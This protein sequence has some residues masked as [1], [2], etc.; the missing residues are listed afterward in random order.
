MRSAAPTPCWWSPG[1]WSCWPPRPAWW[2]A[3]ATSPERRPSRP[4]FRWVAA[5][6]GHPPAA[7]RGRSA[8]TAEAGEQ[9]GERVGV[10]VDGD[11]GGEHSGLAL[12]VADGLRGEGVDGVAHGAVGG[13]GQAGAV[14]QVP[15]V[16]EGFEQADPG[17]DRA[18]GG[19][20]RERVAARE[21]LG[22]L[23]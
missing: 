13:V 3:G 23:E 7:T 9:G 16:D 15:A 12:R 2:C 8:S 1:T 14:G 11:R 21:R 20:G 22:Q 4:T 17:Q 6:G 19:S 5:G 18:G 10:A